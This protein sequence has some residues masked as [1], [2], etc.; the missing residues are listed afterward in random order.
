MP[1]TLVTEAV[2]IAIYGQL[3]APSAPVE[4]LLPYT[5]VV[6]LYELQTSLD[7]LMESK[8]EDQHVKKKISQMLQYFEEPLNQKKI[9]RALQI[10]WA[11]SSPILLSDLVS[12]RIVNALDTAVLGELFDPIETELLL[13]SQRFKTPLL[14]DQVEWISRILEAKVPVQIYDIDDFEYAVENNDFTES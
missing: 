8:H 10:P 1:R 7:P 4:Y 2:M 9:R 14:T 11:L 6:E 12:I 5:T 13:T 3:L